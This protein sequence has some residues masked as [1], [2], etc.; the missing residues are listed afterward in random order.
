MVLAAAGCPTHLKTFAQLPDLTDQSQCEV[1]RLMELVPLALRSK[2]LQAQAQLIQ[3]E[4]R[5][6]VLC[7]R[8]RA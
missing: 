5:P 8:I 1:P 4:G 3:A 6:G 7:I 2:G